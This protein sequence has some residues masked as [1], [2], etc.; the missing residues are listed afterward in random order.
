MRSV[1]G[2]RGLEDPLDPP[3]LANS[4][5]TPGTPG[6]A[7]P[8]GLKGPL[9][10]SG[11]P[12]VQKFACPYSMTGEFGAANLAGSAGVPCIEQLLS[13]ISTHG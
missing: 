4:P 13:R 6:P 8:R 1:A 9:G 2:A 7:R 5:E 3:G 12:G 11:Q 10:V